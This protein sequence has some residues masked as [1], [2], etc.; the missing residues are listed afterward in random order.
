M[1]STNQQQKIPTLPT[2]MVSD[3]GLQCLPTEL[4]EEIYILSETLAL[5]LVCRCFYTCLNT[6]FTRLRFCTRVFFL[7]NPNYLK[8]D[9]VADLLQKQENIILAQKWFTAEFAT[10]VED[11]VRKIDED[12][13]FHTCD[14]GEQDSWDDKLVHTE[15][16]CPYT[17][18]I[19][20]QL[21]SVAIA[22]TTPEQVH[23]PA[24]LLS[25]PWTSSK[26]ALLGILKRWGVSL[27][28][29]ATHLC[30][31]AMKHATTPWDEWESFKLLLMFRSETSGT[32]L[33][34]VDFFDSEAFMLPLSFLLNDVVRYSASSFSNML[35]RVKKDRNGGLTQRDPHGKDVD[36]KNGTFVGGWDEVLGGS[37]VET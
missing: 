4:I 21:R 33:S 17:G 34:S 31:E 1:I 6:E 5:S 7:G 15:R 29:A 23:L 25:G 36:H 12:D 26:W 11:A 19:V 13:V 10:K 24:R 30:Y 8:P 35:A 20:T 27:N 16:C 2:S 3:N 18:A 32:S 14:S 28:D 37:R 9:V 22:I